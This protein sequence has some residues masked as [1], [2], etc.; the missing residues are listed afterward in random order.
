[1]RK[2][3]EK[4]RKL[5]EKRKIWLVDVE[6]VI[7]HEDNIFYLFKSYS[8]LPAVRHFSGRRSKPDNSYK[9]KTEADR[10]EWINKKIKQIDE[11]KKRKDAWNAE[12]KAKKQ[13]LLE[14]VKVGDV[15]YASWGYE[16]T[17]I[18]YYQVVGKKGQT[19]T[20]RKI[21]SEIVKQTGPFSANVR[22]VK[23]DFIGEPFKKRVSAYSIKLD[24]VRYI[25]KTDWSAVHHSSWGH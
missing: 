21:G 16:Q 12:K 15:F 5:E 7:E 1:M 8:G 2:I 24:S 25:S 14:S 13:A 17:N 22:P 18:D 4:A 10:A 19:L 20:F 3:S 9:F 23:D 11:M 6:D